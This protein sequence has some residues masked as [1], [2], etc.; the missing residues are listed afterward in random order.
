M[1]WSTP[2][3]M[4]ETRERARAAGLS[5]AELPPVADVDEPDDLRHLPPGW[6]PPAA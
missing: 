3:V 6:L 1:R 5:W 2:T 4:T